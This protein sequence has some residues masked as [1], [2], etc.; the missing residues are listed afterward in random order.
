MAKKIRLGM[1]G[2]GSTSFI[3]ILHRVASYISEDYEIIGGVFDRNYDDSLSFARDMNYDENRVYPDVA[4]FVEKENALPSDQRIEAVIIVTPNV[5]HYDQAKQLIEGNFHVICE[6]PVTITA[7]EALDLQSALDKHKVVFGVTHTYTGYPMVREMKARIAEGVIG[8]VQKVDAQYYQGWINAPI[9]NK[10]LRNSIWRLDPKV[11]GISSCFGDIGVHAF[12]MIEYVTGL[13]TEKVLADLNNVYDDNQ[14]DV[15]GTAFL[16]FKSNGARG[17]VRASQI[18]TGEE[19]NLQIMV[20]GEKGGFKWRQEEPTFL[21]QF[22][23]GGA[24]KIIKPGQ[25]YTSEFAMEATRMAP[26]HPEG[27]FDSM[28]NI[29]I[30]IAKAIRGES[31]RDGAFPTIVDGV[32]GMQFIEAVVASNAAGQTWVNIQ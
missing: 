12:N 31:Y 3:G 18:A 28:G 21:Y 22:E 16:R 2:G 20:Y 1:I 32:R 15:D 23:E 8:K 9:H 6:K 17:L 10:E 30:G 4:T 27:I 25:P 13:E 7:Q 19:N 26:G 5:L 29:Y 14:L 11:A 24:V